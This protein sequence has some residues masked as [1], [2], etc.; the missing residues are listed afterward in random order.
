[1]DTMQA[2]RFAKE[3]GFDAVDVTAYYIPGFDFYTMPTKPR[4]EIM[5]YARDIRAL[6]EELG[7]PISGT[8]ASNDFADP[9]DERRALDMER[10]KFWIDAAAEMG[11]PV[12][13]VF[14]GVVPADID[15]LGWET[16]ARTR[17]VPAIRELAAYG[18]ARGVK[19]GLQN[20]GDMTATAD[21]TIQIL[22][23]VDD[24]NV[25]IVD[26]TGYFRPFRSETGQDYNWYADI[27]K[28]LPY[29]SNF[30]LKKKP[31]GAETEGLMDLDRVFTDIRLSGY[32]GYIPMELL[33]VKGEPGYPR[34]LPEP[35]YDQI[36]RFLALVKSAMDRTKAS[37]FEAIG[38]SVD[39]LAKAGEV[40]KPVSAQLTN[41]VRQ[42]EHHFAKGHT[43][44]SMKQMHDFLDKVHK[45]A[46]KRDISDNA[47]STLEP[48]MDA[49]LQS[50]T[51]V[52]P[53]V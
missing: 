38:R 32:R 51:D 49:L 53:E 14:S 4:E 48:Q 3:A 22:R 40:A 6:T 50:F 19:I 23:W 29:T 24:P 33:W 10:L 21:Q 31:A 39:R 25:G 26:D 18:A 11:A 12:M 52:F 1:M 2:I 35:P 30:Q 15:Q 43:G 28:V 7:I 20:H 34:D 45:A 9:S 27:A 44:Q 8:G 41:A 42:A 5:R 37:P 13:R 46:S 16:V 47:R 17:I 36:E